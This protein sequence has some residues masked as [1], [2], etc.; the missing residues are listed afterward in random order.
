MAARARTR[1]ARFAHVE[2]RSLAIPEGWPDI[3]EGPF[4]LVVLSEVA[5][6]LTADGL[7]EVLQRLD[8]TLAPSA[9]VIAVHWLGETNYPLRGEEVHAALA[10]HPGLVSRGTYR[11]REFVLDVYER[12]AS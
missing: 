10:A 9:N 5:Y 12:S 6:Y 1:V 11:E 7:R 8:A 3:A 2:V 4:D